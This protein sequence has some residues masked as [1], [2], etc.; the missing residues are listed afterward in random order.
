M[1]IFGSHN[2][3]NTED[4]VLRTSVKSIKLLRSL[5]DEGCN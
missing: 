5:L 3:S 4:A 2:A 1:S